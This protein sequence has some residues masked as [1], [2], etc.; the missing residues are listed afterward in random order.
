M[1]ILSIIK[2]I[3]ITGAAITGSI[4]A[5]KGLST[6]Q[7]Q[8][9]GQS[10]YDLSRRIL[11]SLFKYRDAINGV[12]N[13]AMWADEMPSPPEEKSKTM[14]SDQ[15][16]FYGTSNAYQARWDKVQEERTSL[17]ADLLEAEAIWGTEL[18]D[19]FKVVF[20][21][22][23]ELFTRIRHYLILINPDL[24]EAKKTAI[25]KIDKNKRDII[26]DDLGEKPDEYKSN[27]IDAIKVIESYLKPKLSH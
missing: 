4:V 7:R 27:L 2:E 26:Y 24:T 15:I 13:P 11:V 16:S 14:N 22:Q 19:L 20:D 23:H 12:R 3:V 8:L 10:E 1:E 18:N 5:V 25:E 17:Y 9:K 6:W 21:L